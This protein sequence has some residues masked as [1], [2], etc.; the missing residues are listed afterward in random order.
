MNRWIYSDVLQ[1]S[2]I[3]NKVSK[4]ML[5]QAAKLYTTYYLSV[6]KHIKSDNTEPMNTVS[7]TL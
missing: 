7:K 3:R 4:T 1:T 6:P 2:T 5:Q